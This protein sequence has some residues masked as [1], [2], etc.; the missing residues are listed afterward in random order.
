VIAS[1][2]LTPITNHR[3]NI[4]VLTSIHYICID[5]DTLYLYWHRYN[6][7]VLTSIQ[8]FV[9]TSIQYFVLTSIQY[10]VLTSIH[11]YSHLNTDTWQHH[12]DTDTRT[13][14]PWHRYTDSIT[15]T[16]ILTVNHLDTDTSWQHH[17]DTDTY[18]DSPW[19]RYITRFA[20]TPIHI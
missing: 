1:S 19:H 17:L 18:L 5:I 7:F 4:F 2:S 6:I 20:L 11:G 13:A 10:I 16:P 15:L 9:L 8:Y 12:L 3:Y 14:S